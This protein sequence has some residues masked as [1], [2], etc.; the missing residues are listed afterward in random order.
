[1]TTPLE[2]ALGYAA[3]CGVLPYTARKAP[4]KIEGFF[5]HGVA[6]ATTDAAVITAT[7]TKYKAAE[8]GLALPPGVVVV[9]VDVANGKQGRADFIRLFGCPPEEMPCMD[10]PVRAR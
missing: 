8:I 4:I 3:F 1:M 6:S 5:E 2:A 7:W 10:A 9:D